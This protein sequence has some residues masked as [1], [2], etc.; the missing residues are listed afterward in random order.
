MLFIQRELERIRSSLTSGEPP[1]Y[2]AELYAA[3]QALVWVLDSD[4]FKAPHDLLAR[5]TLEDLRGC[6][7]GNDRSAFSDNHDLHDS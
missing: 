2:Y 7:E 6:R 5:S 4:T 3:Q 1:K